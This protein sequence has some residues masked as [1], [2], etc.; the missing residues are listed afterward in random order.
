M[1]PLFDPHDNL[2]WIQN[3]S[4]RNIR[5]CDIDCQKYTQGND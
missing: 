2:Q 4:R 5:S 1:A 3:V